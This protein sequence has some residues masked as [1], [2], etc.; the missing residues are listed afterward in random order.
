MLSA[1]QDL[2][3]REET[4]PEGIGDHMFVFQTMEAESEQSAIDYRRPLRG[5]VN[6]KIMSLERSG[7]GHI[8]I[9]IF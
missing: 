7:E 4:E 1:L 5:E 8:P 6:V 3:F 9:N 2:A